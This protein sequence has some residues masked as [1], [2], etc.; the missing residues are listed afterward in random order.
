MN[1]DWI[2]NLNPPQRRAVTH[3]TGPLLVLAG[4]GSGKTR[5]L[6]HR[7]AY[8]IDHFDVSPDAIVAVTF[9]NRA[10]GEMRHRVDALLED[11]EAASR[12][13]ISTFHSLGA[14]LLRRFAPRAQLSW[15]FSIYDDGDQ[16][17]LIG[18]L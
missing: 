14:R 2:N 15:N 10:A 4:A 18:A 8:L 6:T 9:T 3:H 1:V 5:V 13:V 16:R 11:K 17:R 7:V 12:V